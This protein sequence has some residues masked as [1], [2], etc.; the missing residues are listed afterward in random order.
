MWDREVI[1]IPDKTFKP[2]EEKY[3][4]H[5]CNQHILENDDEAYIC[6]MCNDVAVHERCCDDEDVIITGEFICA[7][8]ELLM[9]TIDSS[10]SSF[11]SS[12]HGEETEYVMNFLQL[13][14]N[15]SI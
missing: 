12:N 2:E 13:I 6:E 10:S 1:K 5:V 14:R 7:G 11:D 8:C 3:E 15:N 4:C 9:D